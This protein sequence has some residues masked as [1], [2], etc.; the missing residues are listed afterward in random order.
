MA[1]FQGFIGYVETK[2]TAP[3]VLTE[4]VTEHSCRGDMLRDNQRWENS[5]HLNDN[6]TINNQFSIVGDA[7]AYNNF[8]NIRYIKW[9]G[10]SWKVISIEIRRP[11]LILTVGGVYNA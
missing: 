5:G 10:S 2:K 3:G 4:V 11:R 8:Q 1:K 6:L 9:K 7:F